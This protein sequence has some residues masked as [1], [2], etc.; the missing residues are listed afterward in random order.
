MGM[1]SA[2]GDAGRGRRVARAAARGGGAALQQPVVHG[3]ELGR[4]AAA[5]LGRTGGAQGGALNA[6]QSAHGPGDSIERGREAGRNCGRPYGVRA[7]A[8]ARAWRVH[9][10]RNAASYAARPGRGATPRGQAPSPVVGPSKHRARAKGCARS[11][12]RLLQLLQRPAAGR[13]VQCRGV[14]RRRAM[15]APGDKAGSST[16][17]SSK[18]AAAA[19]LA[20][21]GRPRCADAAMPPVA[22]PSARSGSP[23]PAAEPRSGQRASPR[24]SDR[25]SA[26][27]RG[28][29]LRPCTPQEPVGGRRLHRRR[30][31]QALRGAHRA[32]AGQAAA[33]VAQ[34]LRL[35]VSRRAGAAPRRAGLPACRAAAQPGLAP[36]HGCCGLIPMPPYPRTL[37][38][39]ATTSGW[40]SP[41]STRCRASTAG[42][43]PLRLRW[44]PASRP[45]RPPRRRARCLPREL[46]A[47]APGVLCLKPRRAALL[48]A[49]SR[50]RPCCARPGTMRCSWRRVCTGSWTSWRS[51]GRRRRRRGR[52]EQQQQQRQRGEQQQAARRGRRSSAAPAP[53][54]LHALTSGTQSPCNPISWCRLASSWAAAGGRPVPACPRPLA[55]PLWLDRPA[56]PARLHARPGA[57]RA[58]ASARLLA[59]AP[60]P[61]S[62]ESRNRPQTAREPASPPHRHPGPQHAASAITDAGR[63]YPR[64]PC[65]GRRCSQ[66]AGAALP[67]LQQAAAD[68]TAARS[69]PPARCH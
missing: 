6:C 50:C 60:P 47:R 67:E 61:L 69:T 54:S 7:C 18:W 36:S 30:H 52:G 26:D 20:R 51:S 58:H 55:C 3:G 59:P 46:L 37:T 56:A 44:G 57:R 16:A 13:R 64:G 45:G 65:E 40:T 33:D 19:G 4:P 21:L 27:S 17:S 25:C 2:G 42:R 8:R 12:D 41:P 23:D 53:S 38:T 39:A 5:G 66:A 10:G 48:R 32:A 14:C 35:G 29:R 49:G 22:P 24:R 9:C 11:R 63:G 1:G 31:R 28:P 62:T 68:T 15:S 34:E 43:Q